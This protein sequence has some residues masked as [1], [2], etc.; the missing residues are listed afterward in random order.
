MS[1]Y[2]EERHLMASDV[3]RAAAPN[4]RFDG[5]SS[6]AAGEAGGTAA[7]TRPLD[8]VPLLTMANFGP[9][10]DIVSPAT[11]DDGGSTPC[12]TPCRGRW[13]VTL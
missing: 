12:D 6:D 10:V 7:R 11:A 8:A 5:T 13:L 9:L 2:G 4:Q 3:S 1:Y